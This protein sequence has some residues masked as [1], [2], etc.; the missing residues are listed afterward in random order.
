MAASSRLDRLVKVL[1]AENL[2]PKLS[3]PG[4]NTEQSD[5]TAK[6]DGANTDD[7]FSE[8]Q[9]VDDF[10]KENKST[11]NWW[12]ATP[13]IPQIATKAPT[14]PVTS[15]FTSNGE[16]HLE[17]DPRKGE[18]APLGVSFSP[19]GAVTKFCYKFVKKDHQQLLAT[20]FFAEGKIYDREWDM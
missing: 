1:G 14:R 20:A 6:Q 15:F 13:K 7:S 12:D 2:P 9:S 18:P 3:K 11:E 5:E 19:F 10:L 4:D 8:L 16:T 17:F